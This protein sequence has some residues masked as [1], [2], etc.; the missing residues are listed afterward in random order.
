MPDISELVSEPSRYL[1]AV[2]PRTENEAMLRIEKA[3]NL[4]S[5]HQDSLSDTELLEYDTVQIECERSELVA[6]APVDHC[7]QGIEKL[8][9]VR[10]WFRSRVENFAEGNIRVKRLVIMG[11]R[12]DVD[13]ANA[14][15][16]MLDDLIA[17]LS[18]DYKRTIEFANNQTLLLNSFYR[19][20]STRLNNRLLTL[21][22]SAMRNR[23]R[24]GVTIAALK[25]DAISK[26]MAKAGIKLGTA[27]KAVPTQPQRPTNESARLGA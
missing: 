19:T 8:C 2:T 17:D 27:P 18:D 23:T 12:P 21:A 5:K 26:A 7:F 25:T 13:L 10:L 20:L 22:S 1:R 3:I 14:L 24:N 11:L 15:Y 6:V 4:T 16:D 9:G